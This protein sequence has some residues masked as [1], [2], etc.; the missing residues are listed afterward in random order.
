MA[1]DKQYKCMGDLPKW[2]KK[3]MIWGQVVN[4]HDDDGDNYDCYD[5]VV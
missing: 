3:N 1:T 2:H 4:M 5:N